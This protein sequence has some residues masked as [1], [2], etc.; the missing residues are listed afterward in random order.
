MGLLAKKV[1]WQRPYLRQNLSGRV[2]R[3]GSSGRRKKAWGASEPAMKCQGS[4]PPAALSMRPR[5]H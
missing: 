5:W 4:T 3:R 2:R 1:S